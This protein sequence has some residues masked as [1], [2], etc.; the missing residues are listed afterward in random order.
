MYHAPTL[1][2]WRGAAED[3]LWGRG[4]GPVAGKCVSPLFSGVSVSGDMP[5]H[6]VFIAGIRRGETVVVIGVW[7]MSGA[8]R[9]HMERS[10]RHSEGQPQHVEPNI[11]PQY[12]STLPTVQAPMG[13]TYNAG[14]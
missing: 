4:I 11:S 9:V 3:L 5:S 13:V 12:C 10:D 2:I 8:W 6:H 14:T 1:G 7:L